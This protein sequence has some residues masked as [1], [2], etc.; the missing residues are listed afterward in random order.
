MKNADK[1]LITVLAEMDAAWLPARGFTRPRPANTYAAQQTFHAGGVEFRPPGSD[2]AARKAMMRELGAL[3][4]AG[5][6]RTTAPRG[7]RWPL[8]RLS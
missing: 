6:V 1:A 8:V 4:R 5:A 7:S 2:E 3:E